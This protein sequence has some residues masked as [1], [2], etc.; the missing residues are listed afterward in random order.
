MKRFLLST[1]FISL[2]LASFAFSGFA[3][4]NEPKPPYIDSVLQTLPPINFDYISLIQG[5]K[6][7]LPLTSYLFEHTGEIPAFSTSVSH[8][9]VGDKHNPPIL[10]HYAF[11]ML[12]SSAGGF[13]PPLTGTKTV[14]TIIN[15][16]DLN[17]VFENRGIELVDEQEW[18]K[19]P[20]AFRKGI[21]E[22][23]ESM[24]ETATVFNQ[25]SEPIK[26]F[27]NIKKELPSEKI[28]EQLIIPWNLREI[29]ESSSVDVIDHADL[30]KL[31]FATRLL[32]EKLNWFFSQSGLAIP[33]DFAGCKLKTSL[34]ECLI[35][36]TNNDT[37]SGGQFFVVEL[38]GDDVYLG[39]TASPVSCTQPFGIV[40]DRYGND[41][42]LCENNFLV[43]GILGIA[44]LLDL[45]GDDLYNTNKPGLA[46]SLYG[47]SMLYDYSGNDVYIG[48]SKHSQAAS[49]LGS[50]LLVDVSGDDK[51]SCKS[52]SQA[53]G[54][55]LGVGI[56]YDNV[57]NDH[58]NTEAI[59]GIETVQLENFIQ[60]A[61]KGRWAE[62][63]DGQSLA[64]G[65]GVFIDNS[66]IDKYSA[67]SFSQ[68]ASYYFGLGIFSENAGNDFYDAIS[69][70]QGYAAHYS[71]AAFWD[72]HG[73]DIYNA[74]SDEQKI[75]QIIGSGRDYSAGLFLE[76][77][78]NDTYFFGNRSAG[79]ADINGIGFFADYL[80]DDQY[81]WHKN[82]VNS[83]S[84]SLG[85]KVGLSGG[86][87]MGFKVFQPKNEVQIGVFIDN[88]G[89]NK[90]EEH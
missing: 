72:K 55:T 89:V 15:E 58:Y 50:S 27:L 32:T 83:G 20:F 52:N 34:G 74:N 88:N 18:E 37:I 16:N 60:G 9:I 23:L 2:L 76:Y 48:N 33:K 8:A 45:N 12:S 85:K 38:G 67:G 54:G 24:F 66:G 6:H 73:N 78:G 69:H 35:S 4:E 14:K 31:S 65:V 43:A 46:F 1:I 40:V 59:T 39:N 90:F 70:S 10:F 3:E 57:G 5:V 47:S 62:A 26:T 84:P 71:L 79:I 42:Y 53:F 7:V 68:G 86:M 82:S 49:Y 28:Y 11:Q 87:N 21:V 19:L 25:F 41:N 30:K 56:F 63:T 64:G 13:G 80:G 81:S 75:T 44:I 77:E 61:S 22:I 17:Q 51:Y 36:G 29:K